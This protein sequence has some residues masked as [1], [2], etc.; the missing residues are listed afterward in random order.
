MPFCGLV[1]QKRF[2]MQRLCAILFLALLPATVI[3]DVVVWGN[4]DLSSTANSVSQMGFYGIQSNPT[5]KINTSTAPVDLYEWYVP[6]L[7][8]GSVSQRTVTGAHVLLSNTTAV[9]FRIHVYST[10]GGSV[11]ATSSIISLATTGSQWAY[12]PLTSP[13]TLAE[14]AKYFLAV[15]QMQTSGSYADAG[16][17][18]KNVANN[19][20]LPTAMGSG[21]GYAVPVSPD[22]A[23]FFTTVSGGTQGTPTP[24]RMSSAGSSYVP[25]FQITAVPE[26]GSLALCG[27]GAAV[28][29]G[30]LV[31]RRRAS[32]RVRG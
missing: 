16:L 28:A 30:W 15:E 11:D 13:V 7:A 31:V 23:Y 21:S 6:F 22:D 8:G 29:C 17:Y 4:G 19:P 27:T 3:G 14:G 26:P 24:Y 5:P 1:S 12:A 25:G 18:W 10:A 32:S 20:Q 9:D 2:A